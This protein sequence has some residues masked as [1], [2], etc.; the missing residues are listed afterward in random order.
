ML[1]ELAVDLHITFTSHMHTHTHTH[2]QVVQNTKTTKNAV[3][4]CK[5]PC[6]QP[7]SYEHSFVASLPCLC[8]AFIHSYDVYVLLARICHMDT[9][10]E[11]VAEA[12]TD[13]P[14]YRKVYSSFITF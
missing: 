2:T 7:E 9:L 3:L 5:S 8:G 14:S 1:I 12:S 13:H 6:K 11:A 4:L 10:N